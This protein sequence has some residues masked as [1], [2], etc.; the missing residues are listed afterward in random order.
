MCATSLPPR[1]L[2]EIRNHTID[3]KDRRLLVLLEANTRGTNRARQRA[4][5]P[6]YS[7]VP[8]LSYRYALRIEKVGEDG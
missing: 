8:F 3:A 7:D 5:P 4:T 6:N 1:R 2:R